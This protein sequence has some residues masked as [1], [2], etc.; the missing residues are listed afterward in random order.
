[1]PRLTGEQHTSSH[2]FNVD[3]CGCQNPL[4]GSATGYAIDGSHGIIFSETALAAL[5]L[6]T[7]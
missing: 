7:Y 3:V 5:P 4:V 1:M 6:S 2:Q